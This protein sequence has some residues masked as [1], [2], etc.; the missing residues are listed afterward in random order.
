MIITSWISLLQNDLGDLGVLL[1]SHELGWQ[2]IRLFLQQLSAKVLHLLAAQHSLVPIHL[3]LRLRLLYLLLLQ[4]PLLQE[5]PALLPEVLLAEL[6]LLPDELSGKSVKDNPG[7]P[8][9]LFNLLLLLQDAVNGPLPV[10]LVQPFVL[11]D[12]V[13][14]HLIVEDVLSLREGL[15]PFD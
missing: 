10:A 8:V 5:L 9:L 13:V 11:A 4:L 7:L 12:F 2:V 15:I 1:L 6:D 14:V 3:P